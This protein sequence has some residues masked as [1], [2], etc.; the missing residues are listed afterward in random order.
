MGAAEAGEVAVEPA[1][2]APTPGLLRVL[3]GNPASG[4]E[5]AEGVEVEAE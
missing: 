4:A 1:R 2:T 5:E 3:A